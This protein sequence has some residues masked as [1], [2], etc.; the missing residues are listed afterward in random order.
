M[1]NILDLLKK[2]LKKCLKIIIWNKEEL[3]KEW[4]NGYIFGDA[5]CV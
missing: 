3:I 4:Y 5:E 1:M 2:K